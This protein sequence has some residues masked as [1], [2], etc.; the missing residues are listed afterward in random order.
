MKASPVVL[1]H[2][3]KLVLEVSAEAENVMKAPRM[4]VSHTGDGQELRD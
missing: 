4:G 3:L 1:W 2:V